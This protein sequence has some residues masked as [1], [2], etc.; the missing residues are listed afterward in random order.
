ML[1][2]HHIISVGSLKIEVNWDDTVKPAQ[3]FRFTLGDVTEIVERQDV[4]ALLFLFGTDEQQEL[5]T[6]VTKEV[7]KEVTRH[8]RI[9][10]SKDIKVGDE[11]VVPYKFKLPLAAHEAMLHGG[12]LAFNPDRDGRQDGFMP[13]E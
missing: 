4:Y 10:A 12:H 3:A 5:L 2:D 11:I 9:K 13:K 6:P 7:F 1:S 8:L